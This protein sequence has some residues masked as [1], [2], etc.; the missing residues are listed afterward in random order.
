[1]RTASQKNDRNWWAIQPLA[2]VSP[3]EAGDGWARND[4]DRFIAR[5]LDENHLKPAAA[6]GPRELI[7]RI[8]FDLHGLPPSPQAVADFVSAFEENPDAAVAALTDEL[9][10]SPR[11]GERWGQHWLDV[12]RYAESDGYRAD[13]YRPDTWRYRDYVIRSFNEDKPYRPVRQG[14]AGSR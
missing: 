8:H 7:R 12:V 5:K 9:L 6:A 10:A 13:G 1:M 14:T 2:Q 3:P 4:I 11:Y